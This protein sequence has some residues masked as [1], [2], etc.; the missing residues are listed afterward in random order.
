MRRIK[1]DTGE[2]FLPHKNGDGYSTLADPRF[3]NQKHHSKNQVKVRT[4]EEAKALV[5]QGFHLRMRGVKTGQI[6]LIKPE[7]IK[8]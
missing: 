7:D 5:K 1:K 3:G 4:L 6:N 2:L 8:F